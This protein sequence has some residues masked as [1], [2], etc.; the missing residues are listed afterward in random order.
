MEVG[1]KDLGFRV[2]GLL[3]ITPIKKVPQW[4][5]GR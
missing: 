2:Y 5:T 4:K 3:T 1:V